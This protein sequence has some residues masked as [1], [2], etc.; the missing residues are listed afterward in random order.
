MGS[1]RDLRSDKTR[2]MF[3]YLTVR[4]PIIQ[5]RE[6]VG[7]LINRKWK[8]CYYSEGKHHQPQSSRACN[9]HNE[10]EQTTQKKT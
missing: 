6:G 8:D 10:V 1:N 3:H 4:P 2:G 9:V 5:G 7:F